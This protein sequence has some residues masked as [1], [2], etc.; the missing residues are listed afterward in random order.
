MAAVAVAPRSPVSIAA[1]RTSVRGTS[2]A[3]ET[4]STITPSRAPCRISPISRPRRKSLLVVRGP[5]EQIV[6]RRA[7]GRLGAGAGQCADPGE[8]AASTSS[9]SNVAGAGA[10]D[11]RSFRDAHPTPIDPCGSTPER[12]ATA[13]GTSPG[14]SAARTDESRSTFSSRDEVAAT[15]ADA[16]ATSPRSIRSLRASGRYEPSGPIGLMSWK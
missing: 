8:C 12:Y 15:S 2:A 13:I 5:C 11:G 10:G 6:E 4:A 14:S 3:R 1:R 7:A 9:S 16:A